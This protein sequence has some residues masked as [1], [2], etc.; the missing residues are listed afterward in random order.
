[1]KLRDTA[2]HLLSSRIVK[3]GL[4]GILNAAFG[5]GC[6]LTL[7]VLGCS[8]PTAWGGALCISLVFSFVMSGKLIFGTAEPSRFILFVAAWGLIYVM[9]IILIGLLLP[10]GL[11]ERITP[12]LMIPIN[13]VASYF[14][15]LFVVFRK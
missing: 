1:L 9:N 15:Q 10:L 12:L 11:G 8:Y 4:V 3:F 14:V 5:Y 2:K 6:Y 7:L 13:T